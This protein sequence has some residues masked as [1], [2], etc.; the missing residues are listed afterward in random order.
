MCLNLL[1]LSLDPIQS[2]GRPKSQPDLSDSL[3]DLLSKGPMKIVDIMT[4]I[5]K[6]S[7]PCSKRTVIRELNNIATIIGK[8]SKSRW[9]LR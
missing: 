7:M 6:S 4:A 9:R 5:E 3:K 1:L 8:G 2:V